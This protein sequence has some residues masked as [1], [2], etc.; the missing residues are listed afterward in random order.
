V[1]ADSP[2]GAM[3]ART[4]SSCSPPQ[5]LY[6]CGEAD[7]RGKPRPYN[8]LRATKGYGPRILESYFWDGTLVIAGDRAERGSGKQLRRKMVDSAHGQQKNG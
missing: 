6:K 4:S 2:H 7:G 8:V 5:I 3:R 1:K